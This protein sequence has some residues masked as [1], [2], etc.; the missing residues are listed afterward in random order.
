VPDRRHLSDRVRHG[1]INEDVCNGC[2]LLLIEDLGV[3]IR[4]MNMLGAFKFWD[5]MSLGAWMVGVFGMFTFVSSVLSFTS[6][7]KM[8][9]L[10]RKIGLVGMVSGFF[11]AA[12]RACFSG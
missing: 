10:R 7:E 5:P 8:A 9:A 1:N 3:P 12:T 2:G 6:S 11:L 4:F